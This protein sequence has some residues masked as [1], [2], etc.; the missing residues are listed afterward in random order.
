MDANIFTSYDIFEL[1][2][3]GDER[4]GARVLTFI[5]SYSEKEQ[6]EEEITTFSPGYYYIL[7]CYNTL[8]VRESNG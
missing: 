4:S 5:S 6:A 7:P 3:E 2:I 1:D 8:R